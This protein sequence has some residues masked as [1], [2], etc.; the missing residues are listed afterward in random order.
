MSFQ[1]YFKVLIL[2]GIEHIGETIGLTHANLVFWAKKFYDQKYQR[3]KTYHKGFF[4]MENSLEGI[5]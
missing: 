3:F 5:T 4:P 1:T 2:L